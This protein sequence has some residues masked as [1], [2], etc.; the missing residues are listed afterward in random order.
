[1]PSMV[2]PTSAL[3][4]KQRPAEGGPLSIQQLQDD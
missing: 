1:L 4:Q 2:V 3:F